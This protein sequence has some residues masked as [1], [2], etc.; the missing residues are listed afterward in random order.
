MSNRNEERYMMR[1]VAV[2]IKTNV[3]RCCNASKRLIKK[4]EKLRSMP[5]KQPNMR[6]LF[7][8]VDIFKD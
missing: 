5:N 2:N 6:A 1:S 7:R 3:S 8:L 4:A